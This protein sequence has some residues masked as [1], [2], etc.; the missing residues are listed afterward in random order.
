MAKETGK[1]LGHIFWELEIKV[2]F[3][4]WRRDVDA[5]R[6]LAT[7]GRRMAGN[8]KADVRDMKATNESI[9][10]ATSQG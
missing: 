5:F 8:V 9:M 6:V 4:R 10:I 1:V 2:K 3:R 7:A